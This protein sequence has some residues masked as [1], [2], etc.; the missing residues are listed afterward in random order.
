MKERLTRRI[1]AAFRGDA[2]T[3]AT[4]RGLDWVHTRFAVHDEVYPLTVD[5]VASTTAEPLRVV[6][7][8]PGGGLN[9][10]GNFFTPRPRNL[11]HFLREHGY[12]VVGISPRE[13][14]LVPA[15]DDTVAAGWGLAKRKRD[16]RSVIS[17]IN[18]ALNMP[19]DLL[20]HSVGGLQALDYA[21]TYPD[22]PGKV[23]VLDT[24]GPY[25]PSTE[26]ALSRRARDTVAVLRDLLDPPGDGDAR[27]NT[28]D[29]GLKALVS[30]AAADP[31]GTAARAFRPDGSPFTNAGLAHYALIKTAELP[32]PLNWIYEQGLSAGTYTLG[33]TPQAD[34]FAFAHTSLSTWAAA[35][36]EIGSGLLVTAQLRDLNAVLAA[37]PSSY[38]IDWARIDTRVAWVNMSLGRGDH[39]YGARLIRAG[40]NP[41]VTFTVVPGY[42]H[43]DPTWGRAAHV[44]V[45]PLLTQCRCGDRAAEGALGSGRC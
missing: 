20:G 39:P 36:A 4:E 15:A 43:G 1:N 26:P 5:V 28:I 40:G 30:A 42:G 14:A 7:M 38:A 37:D 44:D 16:N 10:R 34:R 18:A 29:P 21:A 33:E 19:Y 25:E 23:M 32:G 24:T 17:T 27:Q 35:M 45:W 31:A 12:L 3:V 8:L 9:F 22:G 13:D 2:L 6:Y 11:A 41:D